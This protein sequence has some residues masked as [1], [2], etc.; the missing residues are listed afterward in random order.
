MSNPTIDP[1]FAIGSTIFEAGIITQESAIAGL[2]RFDLERRMGFNAGHLSRGYTVAKLEIVP[3]FHS[4]TFR[5]HTDLAPDPEWDEEEDGPDQRTA[6]EVLIANGDDVDFMKNEVMR[7]DFATS[8]P[9]RLIKIIPAF[10]GQ[11]WPQYPERAG[12]PQVILL[13]NV[14]MTVVAFVGPTETYTPQI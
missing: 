13:S 6:E 14:A 2:S 3:G 4:W 5:R 11:A 12:A 8:G 7:Y 9:K 10:N 1:P